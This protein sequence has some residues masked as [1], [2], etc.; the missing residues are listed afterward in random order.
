MTRDERTRDGAP[1]A[2]GVG[3]A[4]A[5]AMLACAILQFAYPIMTTPRE[6]YRMLGTPPDVVQASLAHAE[7][8]AM[9]NPMF[10][11]AVVGAVLGGSLAL[12]RVGAHRSLAVGLLAAVAVAIAG[13]VFGGLSG[14][15]GYVV[16]RAAQLSTP[17]VE[18]PGAL[19]IHVAVLSTLG[20]G[21]GLSLRG[22]MVRTRK[23]AGAGVL[24]GAAAGFLAGMVFP[25]LMAIAAP[26][27]KTGEVVPE[28]LARLIWIGLVSLALGIADCRVGQ[29]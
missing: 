19:A 25:V 29:D 26:A 7:K 17:V 3:A 24:T 2:S 23:A 22:L 21:L 16:H 12:C 13:T 9:V 14:Y 8:M 6:L 28:G 4:I 15:V 11:L 1:W 20:A 27:V 5:G 18:L 10:A